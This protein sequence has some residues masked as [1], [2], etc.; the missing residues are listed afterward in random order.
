MRWGKSQA[1][2]GGL[3]AGA[4]DAVGGSLGAVVP[5]MGMLQSP[6]EAVVP[7]IGTWLQGQG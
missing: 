7:G 1:G 6:R 4:G 3:F 5:S 2:A